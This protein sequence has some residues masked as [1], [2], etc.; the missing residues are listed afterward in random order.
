MSRLAN[1]TTMP[2]QHLP[3]AKEAEE[4]EE[5]EVSFLQWL[6][7]RNVVSCVSRPAATQA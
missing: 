6:D 5:E 2:H 7:K 3:E 1:I 4:E